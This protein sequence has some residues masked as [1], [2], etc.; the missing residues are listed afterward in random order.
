MAAPSR[1][2]SRR[3]PEASGIPPAVAE[4]RAIRRQLLKES[5]GDIEALMELARREASR[6][7]PAR[8]ASPRKRPRR[9]A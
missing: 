9:A 5:G 7:P 3:S 8:T 2:A 4:V 1:K 6:R